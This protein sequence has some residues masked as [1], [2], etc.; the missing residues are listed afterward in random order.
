MYRVAGYSM[1]KLGYAYLGA[2]SW[3]LMGPDLLL[4]TK[5][6]FSLAGEW[7]QGDRREG[8]LHARRPGWRVAAGRPSGGSAACTVAG[9]A[10]RLASGNRATVG[11][12]GCMHGGAHGSQAGE[13]SWRPSS[14]GSAACTVGRAAARLAS[15]SRATVG[16]VGCMH[17]GAHGGQAG[18]WRQGDRREG[19]LHA[20]RRA[21]RP[22]WRVAAGRPSGGST[23]CTAA[24]TAARLASGGRAT[25]GR[26]GAVRCHWRVTETVYIASCK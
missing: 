18:E 1:S 5:E 12:V 8:R 3:L 9:T 6:G 2:A 20:R 15:G 24:R 25:V 16:R 23:A 21:R 4:I 26:V 22:G 13:W 7:Q 11:R 19:R 10:A 17:G 14:G